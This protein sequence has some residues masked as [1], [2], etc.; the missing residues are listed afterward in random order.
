M[1][2]LFDTVGV[3]TAECSPFCRSFSSPED[4]GR[5]LIRHLPRSFTY[6]NSMGNGVEATAKADATTMGKPEDTNMPS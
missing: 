3:M 6:D 1:S 5:E 4:L 2:K